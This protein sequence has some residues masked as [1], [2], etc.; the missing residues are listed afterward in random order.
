[1]TET[2]VKLTIPFGTLEAAPRMSRKAHADL[3]ESNRARYATSPELA[4]PAPASADEPRHAAS[5]DAH[6]EADTADDWR[7]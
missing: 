3:I 4:R 1:M 7:S 2:A 6:A 5:E